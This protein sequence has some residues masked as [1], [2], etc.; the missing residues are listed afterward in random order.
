M[1]PFDLTSNAENDLKEIDNGAAYSRLFSSRY[2]Q[3]FVTRC[4]HHFIFYLQKKDVKPL[5]IAILHESMNMLSWI[6]ERLNM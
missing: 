1:L 6:E 4:E 3:L 5:I 2:S